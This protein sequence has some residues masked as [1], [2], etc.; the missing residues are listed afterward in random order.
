VVDPEIVRFGVPA[1]RGL[2]IVCKARHRR[3]VAARS[4]LLFS[5]LA[6]LPRPATS[7]PVGPLQQAIGAPAD[8][9]LSGSVR[10]RIESIDGQIR[11]GLKPAETLFMVRTTL[12]AEIGDGPVRLVGEIFDSRAYGVG[13]RSAAGTGE[14][15]VLEPVQAHLRVDLGDVL[16]KGSTAT[17]TAGRMVFNLGSRRLVAADDYRNTTQG[18]TG[19]RFDIA[20]NPVLSATLV[21]VLPQQRL[22]GNPAFVPGNHFALDRESFDQRLWGG[23]VNF[24]R[25]G[26]WHVDASLFGLD[27]RDSPRL[28][29][30]DRSLITL[31]AHLLKPPKPGEF[32]FDVE[33]AW[34]GGHARAG[35]VD[36]LPLQSVSAWF[37][38]AEAGH[39]FAGGWQPHVSAEFDA[40]SGDRPGGKYTRFDTLFGMRRAD[41]SPGSI[42]SAIWRL[43]MLAAGARLEVVPSART[44][45][46]VSA[47]SYWAESG[48]DFFSQTGVRDITGASGR[49]AGVEFDSRARHWLVPER[50]RAEFDG[51]VFLRR[52]LLRDAPNAPAGATTLYGALSLSA[53]F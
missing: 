14:V 1:A 25:P 11:P 22:P 13:P 23:I 43:N 32:D 10:T 8:F 16:G 6:L 3:C 48:S 17:L 21:Y 35:L 37:V 41:F 18:Y 36:S 53:F 30:R 52:G 9:D 24:E 26:G 27:E 31:D 12:R 49:F 4:F 46:F 39:S 15:N 2:A 42:Y 44:D 29:T 47:R 45:A 38:H 7:A 50:L 20:P 5:A 33:A 51:V 40:I 28:P 34:Q 19:V